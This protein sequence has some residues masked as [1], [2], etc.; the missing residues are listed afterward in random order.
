MTINRAIAK[1][2]LTLYRKALILAS[3]SNRAQLAGSYDIAA[4]YRHKT[5]DLLKRAALLRR[6]L[7]AAAQVKE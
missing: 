5:L 3:A 2:A 6:L 4:M 7:D 1:R